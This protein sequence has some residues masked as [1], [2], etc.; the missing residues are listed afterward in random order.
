MPF[1]ENTALFNNADFKEELSYTNNSKSFVYLRTNNWFF[2][3]L[4]T[5]ALPT[6]TF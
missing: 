6:E 4:T 5:Q 1:E 3:L 2:I